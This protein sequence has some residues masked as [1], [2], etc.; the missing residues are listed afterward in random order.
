MKEST[1]NQQ[2]D[3]KEHLHRE[4]FNYLQLHLQKG[5]FKL[6]IKAIY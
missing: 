5:I 1:K 3:L 4:T 6:C 2:I